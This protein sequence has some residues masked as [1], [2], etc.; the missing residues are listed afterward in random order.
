MKIEVYSYNGRLV[1]D[2]FNKSFLSAGDKI[3]IADNITL[4]YEGTYCRRTI[5]F[6]EIANFALT[7]S[8]GVAS[9]VAATWL[10]DKLKGQ[11]V[12]KL[13][14]ERTEVE[15]NEGEIK[16]IIEEKTKIE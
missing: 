2:L 12:E 16:R 6:P 1:H 8:S 5:G 7:F 14:I 15:I 10:Y 3:Q 13:V 4:N 11:K 9:G